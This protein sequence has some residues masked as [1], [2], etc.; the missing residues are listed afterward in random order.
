MNAPPWADLVRTRLVYG[1]DRA[2]TIGDIA[3][4]LGTS[5]RTIEAAVETL[6]REGAPIC[7]GSDGVYLST[8]AR[9]LREHAE[10]L[11]SR[12]IHVLLGARALRTTAR[13]FEKHQQTMI[14]WSEAS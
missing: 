10:R 7:T 12:A 4:Q 3:E 2:R 1:R 14:E 5:R 13:R 6:R 8:D 9:E 11:R